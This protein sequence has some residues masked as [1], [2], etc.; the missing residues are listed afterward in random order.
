MASVT[1]TIPGSNVVSS[2]VDLITYLCSPVISLG[3]DLSASG[4]NVFLYIFSL[5]RGGSGQVWLNLSGNNDLSSD[6]E[7]GGSI[8]VVVREGQFDEQSITI[9]AGN[10][11]S[12]PYT[13]SPSNISDVYDF[14]NFV[15]GLT[16]ANRTLKLTIDDGV[17]ASPDLVVGSFSRTPN[18]VLEVGDPI[19][20]NATVRNDGDAASVLGFMDYYRS[21]DSIL[22]TSDNS[23]GIDAFPILAPGATSGNESLLTNVPTTPGTYYYAAYVRPQGE[24][25][26]TNNNWSS[27]LTVVVIAA[28]SFPVLPSLSNRT[29]IVG[30]SIS[31]FTL[32]AA[33]GGDTPLE[34]TVSGLPSGLSFNS[35]TR[36]VTGTPTTAQTRTVTYTVEDDDGDTDSQVFTFTIDAPTTPDLVISNISRSPTGDVEPGDS[37]TFNVTVRNDGDGSSGAGTIRYYRSSNSS[38]TTSDTQVGTDTFSA[39][40][41][42]ATSNE[43]LTVSVPTTPG[44]YYYGVQVVPQSSES[45][46]G[47]NWSSTLAVV[48]GDFTTPDLIISSFSR[49]PNGVLENSEAITFNATVRNDGDG[50]SSSGTI[51]YHRSTDSTVNGSDTQIG[52]DSFPVLSSG[53]TSNE[54]LSTTTPSTP[55]TYY[56]AVQVWVQTGESNENNNWSDVLTVVVEAPDSSPSLPSSLPDRTGTWGTSLNYTLPTATSGDAPLTYSHSNLPAGLTFNSTTRRV[57][58]TPV[59]NSPSTMF[60]TVEDN[61]GDTDFRSYTLTINAIIP[62]R[63][64]RPRLTPFDYEMDLDWDAPSS[65]GADITDYDVQYRQGSS[66]LWISHPHDNAATSTSIFPLIGGQSY[67]FQV[68]ARNSVGPSLWSLSATDTPT[69]SALVLGTPNDQTLE[70]GTEANILLPVAA[71]GNTPYSYSVSGLPSGLSFSN[72]T[73]RITGSTTVTGT[74]TITYTVED[75][76]SSTVNRTF[77]LTVN[78]VQDLVPELPG[79]SN[80]LL[81][82]G[83]TANILLP[84]ATGGD[85]P[86]VYSVSGLPS[87]LIFSTSTRRIT[88]STTVTGDHTI[89]YTVRDNNNDEDSD[90]FTLTVSAADSLPGFSEIPTQ[91]GTQSTALNILL[92]AANGGDPPLIYSVSGLHSG[93]TFTP[94]TRRIEG[95]PTESGTRTIT[96]TVEDND[97]D[98]ASATF[99]LQISPENLL[100]SLPTV[101]DQLA[102]INTAVDILLPEGSGG[103]PP[104]EYAVIGLSPPLTFNPD[105]RR[106]TGSPTNEAVY[107]VTYSVRDSDMDTASRSFTITI[108][109]SAI[110]TVDE[111]YIAPQGHWTDGKK[112][113]VL[114]MNSTMPQ[115]T[116]RLPA[117]SMDY[118]G[119]IFILT[120]TGDWYRGTS[121][122]GWERIFV[123]GLIGEIKDFGGNSVPEGYLRCDGASYNRT[124][125]ADLYSAIGTTWGIGDGST[126]F[127]VPSLIGFTTAGDGA[128]IYNF[129]DGNVGTR[130]GTD[131]FNISEEELPSHSHEYSRFRLASTNSE[132]RSAVV[133]TASTTGRQIITDFPETGDTGSG[134]FHN[135][136]QPTALV[137]K[138]IK[139]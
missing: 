125:Y 25:S 37:V 57:S 18:G 99:S 92:P 76:T 137:K 27:V 19:T 106:I 110:E 9:L 129:L 49:T 109:A 59:A 33:T 104:L 20:F 46:T 77:S 24:E 34:Y 11:T 95:T 66:G 47:N 111:V 31:S 40:P 26:N 73:R 124:S 130:G 113:D 48:V 133:G 52:T 101:E 69:A 139:F 39:L 13:W 65:N 114:N 6:W 121:G 68:R 84:A 120:T 14:A 75:D 2:S 81:T 105:T 90:T 98:I 23:I 32:P 70:S 135:N 108:S 67:Q 43:S 72:T 116:N 44:T 30:A 60:Y 85:V 8:T 123:N 126:T 79:L 91:T 17:V 62:S 100:P 63:P 29:G 50:P 78:A 87:G 41:P 42:G 71:G 35:N 80:Q 7:T 12:D 122:P 115:V 131:K 4:N 51:S 89:T 112:G 96:Y 53:G 5:P 134:D 15:F 22:T 58:G 117:A 74:R 107:N 94:D 45:D 36:R 61:D 1:V 86:L 64:D 127:N 88:G 103:D 118:N 138:I 10:D 54:S 82:T 38:V 97:G 16:T 102:N 3:S 56:Y 119:M 83:V 136:M 132:Q 28:D 128:N 21:T 93:L 55:G